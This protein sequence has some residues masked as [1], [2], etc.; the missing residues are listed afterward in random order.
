MNE[1]EIMIPHDNEGKIMWS[2]KEIKSTE[3]VDWKPI[4]QTFTGNMMFN[5]MSSRFKYVFRGQNGFKYEVFAK[6]FL[7]MIPHLHDG[8]IA[9]SFMYVKRAGSY[10]I[11]LIHPTFNS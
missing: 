1:N 11:K 4:H 6:D 8:K 2:R 3:N 7:E 10:G 5:G 9:G